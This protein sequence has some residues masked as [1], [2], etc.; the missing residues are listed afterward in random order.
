MCRG[1]CLRWIRGSTGGRK[2]TFHT[3]DGSSGGGQERA[4]GAE[5]NLDGINGMGNG[6]D[7]GFARRTK[8][9]EKM[10]QWHGG[11]LAEATFAIFRVAPSKL[12]GGRWPLVKFSFEGGPP[13]KV[14]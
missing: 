4:D 8:E 12:L 7:A 3:E 10:L 5:G 11:I 14:L 1:R 9:V 2:G 6:R 13:N